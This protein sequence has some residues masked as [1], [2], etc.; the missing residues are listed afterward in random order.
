[1]SNNII[2]DIKEEIFSGSV[3]SKLVI[4]NIFIYIIIFL[5]WIVLL[6]VDG[7]SYQN[8]PYYDLITQSLMLSTDW[9]HN[10]TYPWV[11]FTHMFVHEDFSGLLLDMI[12]LNWFGKIASDLLGS[13]RL[14]PLYLLG[15]IVSAVIFFAL[16]LFFMNGTLRFLVGAGGSINAIL[17]ATI[18]AAPNLRVTLPVVGKVKLKYIIIPIFVLSLI[19]TLITLL[20]LIVNELSFIEKLTIA[21][22]VNTICTGFFGWFFVKLL[23]KGIDL[24]SPIINALRW[25]KTKLG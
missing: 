9:K 16:H 14:L 1:M 25:V 12:L 7:W 11:L 8:P 21:N 18:T 24:S 5:I 6:T 19:S 17:I 3:V 20:T 10:I 22:G 2:K 13:Q 15:G 4:V 23:H